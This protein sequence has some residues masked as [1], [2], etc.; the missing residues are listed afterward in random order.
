M[1]SKRQG[2]SRID[3]RAD[4]LEATDGSLLGGVDE[5][6]GFSIQSGG[7]ARGWKLRVFLSISV[8]GLFT[9]I[10]L[11]SLAL[12]DTRAKLDSLQSSMLTAHDD[13]SES[14][15]ADVKSVVAQLK[16]LNVT[17]TAARAKL[18][19]VEVKSPYLDRKVIFTPRPVHFVYIINL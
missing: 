4:E 17:S 2:R 11:L 10:G 15:G 7:A 3:F 13:L 8:L 18:D 19:A 5:L 1:P 16:E 9:S 6:S 12:W 14:T